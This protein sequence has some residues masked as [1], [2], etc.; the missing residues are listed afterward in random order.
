MQALILMIV[1]LLTLVTV[2]FAG[3]LISRLIDY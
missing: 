3:F 1:Y 2:Q